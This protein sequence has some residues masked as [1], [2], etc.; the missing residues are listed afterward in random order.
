LAAVAVL[1]AGAA[2]VA[3]VTIGDGTVLGLGGPPRLRESTAETSMTIEMTLPDQVDIDQSFSATGL[4]NFPQGRAAV[5][6]D[7]KGLTNAA[8]FFGNLQ[9]F[10]V[11]FA[12]DGIYVRIFPEAPQWVLFTP[13]ELAELRVGRLREVALSSPLLAPL[14]V[15]RRGGLLTKP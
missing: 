12:E 9:Q 14:V 4:V 11:L 1:L 8:G 15:H 2:L 3:Y 6:Y 5:Q 7:F 13:Q 10:R